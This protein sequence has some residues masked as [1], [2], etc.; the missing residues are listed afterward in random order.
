MP[1][2]SIIEIDKTGSPYALSSRIATVKPTEWDEMTTICRISYAVS[3]KWIPRSMQ[4]IE[5]LI[6][7]DKC[8]KGE[9]QNKD[10][11]K[12]IDDKDYRDVTN[13]IFHDA[14]ESVARI[15][16]RAWDIFTKPTAT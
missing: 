11:A 9:L 5:D 15:W 7:K 3:R 10:I 6:G 13:R 4:E 8:K 1:K 12:I 2:D 16:Y 14:V